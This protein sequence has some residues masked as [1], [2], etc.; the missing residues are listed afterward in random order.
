MIIKNLVC[1]V[2]LCTV[3]FATTANAQES[4]VKIKKIAAQF[5]KGADVNDGRLLEDV[6]EPKS[7]QYVLIGGK[8]STF[9]A[10]DYIKMVNEKKLGGKPRK[11][12]YRHAE[13]LGNN[14]AVVVLNAVSEEYDFLY[15]LSMAKSAKG[16]WEIVGITAEINGV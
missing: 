4:E 12:T 7:L 3:V 14:L 2:L 9:S 10:Q 16:K 6:L 5:I 11:I 13:F 15:Q 1:S 8:L